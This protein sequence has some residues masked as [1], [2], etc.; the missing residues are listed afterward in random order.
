MISHWETG[1]RIP[2]SE[3]VASLLT[4]MRVIGTEK[5]VLIELARHAGTA[6]WFNSGTRGVSLGLGAVIESER[7][8][9]SI[10]EWSSG[11]LPGLLQTMDYTRSM[12]LSAGRSAAD[13]DRGS[14]V[15]TD[16]KRI[17]GGPAPVNFCAL[18]N[19]AALRDN[20]G[21]NRVI[22]DQIRHLIELAKRPN[23]TVQVMPLD[24]RWHP[25]KAGP[26]VLY[27]FPDAPAV[28]YFEHYRSSAFDPDPDDVR[29][30]REA[31]DKMREIAMSLQDSVS[32][33]ARLADER[34]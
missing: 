28:V 30:Y 25:G 32:F 12:Y 17:L 9:S 21:D 24:A 8:A 1:R 27:E 16:R 11:V 2:T 6:N 14:V 10:F 19:E 34:E 5:Q 29:A 4:A 20:I 31:A 13:A 33:L 7:A 23:V 26:F 22:A 18:I 15:Q 3:D